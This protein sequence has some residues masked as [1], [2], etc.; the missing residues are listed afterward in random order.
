MLRIVLLA[1]TAALFYVANAQAHDVHAGC[2]YGPYH[3]GTNWHY[4]PGAYGQAVPCPPPGQGGGYGGPDYGPSYG[5]EAGGG[6]GYYRPGYGG[7]YPSDDDGYDD[8]PPPPPPGYY[9]RGYG[10][11]YGRGPRPGEYGPQTNRAQDCYNVYGNRICCPK[12]WTVQNGQ[13]QPYRGR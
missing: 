3:S 9:R 10:G 12:G 1:L 7:G 6:G 8:A 2:A 4:H 5:P 11:G 13:C